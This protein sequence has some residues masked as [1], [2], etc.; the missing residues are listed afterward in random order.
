MKIENKSKNRII[1][2]GD[3]VQFEPYGDYR[4][5]VSFGDEGEY[6]Y[7]A[8]DIMNS[9]VAGKSRQGESLFDFCERMRYRLV[10]KNKDLKLEF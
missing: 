5:I 10:S 3:L 2:C 8:I 1:E 6:F 4:L 9:S 7:L